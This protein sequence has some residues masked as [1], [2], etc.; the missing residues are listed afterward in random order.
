VQ[1]QNQVTLNSA[2]SL[3][4]YRLCQEAISNAAK[5]A[6]ATNL[7]ISITNQIPHLYK[8]EIKDD[9]IGFAAE[10]I[11]GEHYGLQNMKTRAGEIKAHLQL[12]TKEEIGTTIT[13]S[14]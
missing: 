11:Q 9:G 13:I 4:L 3:N 10:T 7:Y 12:E 14:K 6:K 2:E 1:L 8:I 5:Y